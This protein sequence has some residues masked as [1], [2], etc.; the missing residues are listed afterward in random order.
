MKLCIVKDS[1]RVWDGKDTGT[2]LSSYFQPN[3]FSH[4]VLH[5][6][7]DIQIRKSVQNPIPAI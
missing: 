6:R 5:V 3:R 1:K 7:G 2:H 4:L